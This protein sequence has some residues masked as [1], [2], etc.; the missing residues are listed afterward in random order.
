MHHNRCLA[1]PTAAQLSMLV[2]THHRTAL[3][4]DNTF[5]NVVAPTM[6]I[7]NLAMPAAA[8][9]PAA[10]PCTPPVLQQQYFVP[11]GGA[12]T[13][14]AV[15]QQQRLLQHDCLKQNMYHPQQQMF[16]AYYNTQ[17]SAT[18]EPRLDTPINQAVALAAYKADS[19]RDS[20]G[21]KRACKPTSRC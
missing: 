18:P 6:H 7:T 20:H 16:Y 4:T 13:A 17:I 10:L 1:L 8:L 19:H 14:D 5:S 21:V 2:R 15:Q 11:A 12:L 3:H 9:K